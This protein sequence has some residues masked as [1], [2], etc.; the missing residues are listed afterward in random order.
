MASMANAFAALHEIGRGEAPAAKKKKNKKPKQPSTG[1][2]DAPGAPA[3]AAGEQDAVVEV[4]E[5]C[6]VLDKTARTFKSGSDRLKLWKDWIKQASDRSPKAITYTDTDGSLLDFKQ[7]SPG[8]R[9]TGANGRRNARVVLRSRALEITVEGCLS[10]PLPPDHAAHLQQLLATFLPRAGDAPAVAAAVARLAQLLSDDAQSFDTLGAAQRAAFQLVGSLKAEGPSPAGGGGGRGGPV[11]RLA[12][13]D[14]E[15]S[16]L[17]GFLSKVSQGGV[18]KE[19][20]SSARQL[21]SLQ[22]EKM[23]LLQGAG[24]GGGG[25]MSAARK[26]AA[27][28]LGQLKAAISNHLN[29]AQAQEAGSRS[30]GADAARASLQREEGMLSAQAT[31]LAGEIRALEAQLSALRAQAS[32]VESQR[33]R[34]RQRQGGAAEQQQGRG[35]QPGVLS[36]AHYRDELDAANALL[37]VADPAAAAAGAPEMAEARAA[38]ADAPARYLALVRQL[39]GLGL[40]AL[41]ETPAKITNARSRLA[42]ADK[43]AMLASTSKDAAAKA[44]KQREEGEK[45]LGEAMRAAE[46][47]VS[48]CADALDGARRRVALAAAAAPDQAAALGPHARELEDLM[49]HARAQLDLA[50]AAAAGGA[51]AAPPAAPAPFALAP[52]PPAP[53]AKAAAAKAPAAAA[54]AP[55]AAPAPAPAAN[56]APKQQQPARARPAPAAEALAEAPLDGFQQVGGKKNRRPKA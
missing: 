8:R 20:L 23:E 56:G 26:A 13:L 16:K 43:L 31:K 24:G 50:H 36:A 37:A 10:S 19:H 27:E 5:A 29:A 51:A 40:S 47:V 9:R 11:E 53:A 34:L 2:Q 1:G 21:V 52:G 45:L 15:M 18:T 32:E 46:S 6:A 30:S 55:A 14:A 28:S 39:L 22:N 17:Q 7:A 3:A 35:K 42:Q 48:Q 38:N 4:G 49:A 54:K 41:Q 33:Q 44:A 25:G 12:A